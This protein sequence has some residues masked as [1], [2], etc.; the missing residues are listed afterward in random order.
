MDTTPLQG[1]SHSVIIKSEF[2]KDGY[3]CPCIAIGKLT[4]EAQEGM[5]YR[6]AG[7][8]LDNSVDFWIEER[9][10]GKAVSEKTNADYIKIT[11]S[12]PITIVY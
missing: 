11:Y 7:E 9:E 8:I 10:S 4:F 3:D 12:S 6:V 1:G 5:T 2:N